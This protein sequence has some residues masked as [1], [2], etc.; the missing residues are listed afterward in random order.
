MLPALAEWT[1]DALPALADLG[2]EGEPA[3]FTLPHKRSAGDRL[4]D[5]HK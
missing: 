2:Y 1:G 4:G 5:E 3:T